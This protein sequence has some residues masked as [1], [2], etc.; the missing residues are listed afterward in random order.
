MSTDQKE[1]A[2]KT[3]FNNQFKYEPVPVGVKKEYKTFPF[4]QLALLTLILAVIL[5]T[6]KIWTN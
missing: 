6:I 5:A 2:K 1:R 4:A 3:L